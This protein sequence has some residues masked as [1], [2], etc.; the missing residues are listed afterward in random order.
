[1]CLRRK[2]LDEGSKLIK[3]FAELHSVQVTPCDYY[4]ITSYDAIRGSEVTYSAMFSTVLDKIVFRDEFTITHQGPVRKKQRTQGNPECS[5][6]LGVRLLNS[7]PYESF[8][9]SDLK[10]TD[11]V[12]SEIESA[13]YAKF[14]SSCQQK[15]TSKRSVMVIGMSGTTSA[16]TLWIYL[17]A[18]QKYGLSLFTEHSR[19]IGPFCAHCALD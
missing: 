18:H 6:M 2:G 11:S 17:M 12:T 3:N 10:L 16:A 8:Y 1:M 9:V 19:G 14:A 4:S 7:Q 15:S 13:I 5:D